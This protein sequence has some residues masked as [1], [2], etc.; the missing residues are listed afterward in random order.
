MKEEQNE[1]QKTDFPVGLAQPAIRALS[2]AGYTRL[3]QLAEVSEAELKKLHGIGPNSIEQL[4]RALEA[5]GL[6]FA[7][8]EEKKDK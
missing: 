2:G 6:A 4:R 5:Q 7:A 8:G 3:A 1:Q